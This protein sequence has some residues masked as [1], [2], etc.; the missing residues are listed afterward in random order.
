MTRSEKVYFQTSSHNKP[1]VCE[2]KP[3]VNVKKCVVAESINGSHLLKGAEKPVGPVGFLLV[4]LYL[5]TS[6]LAK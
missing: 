5:V 3:A 4:F 2:V 6:V 1:Q